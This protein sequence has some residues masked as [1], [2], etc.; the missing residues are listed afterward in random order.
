MPLRFDDDG[1]T[2]SPNDAEQVVIAD[3]QAMRAKGWTLEAIAEELTELRVPTKMGRS[4]WTHQAVAGILRRAAA[5]SPTAA[6]TIDL[7]CFEQFLLTA[8]HD[9]VSSVGTERMSTSLAF[10]SCFR[11]PKKQFSLESALPFR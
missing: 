2:L 7:S 8:A 4:R 5:Q 10:P 11:V 1:N 6:Y 9:G 3:M